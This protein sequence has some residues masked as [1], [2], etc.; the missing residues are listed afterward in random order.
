MIRPTLPAQ[1]MDR[2]FR[3]FKKIP[4]IFRTSI[5]VVGVIF[6]TVPA[7]SATDI[8]AATTTSVLHGNPTLAGKVAGVKLKEACK[9]RKPDLVLLYDYKSAVKTAEDRMAIVN[10]LAES[11]DRNSIYGAAIHG[12]MQDNTSR[13]DIGVIALGGIKMTPVKVAL[14]AGKEEASYT[15]LAEALKAPYAEAKD[16]GRLV[17]IYGECVPRTN[18]EK[19]MSA[20]TAALGKDVQLFGSPA[21]NVPFTYYQGELLNN[22]LVA[23]LITGDF[24]CNFAMADAAV[25]V[26]DQNQDPDR[27]VESAEKAMKSAVG[28]KKESAALIFVAYSVTRDHSMNKMFKERPTAKA[29]LDKVVRGGITAPLMT[30][31]DDLEIG[32]PA[33]GEPAVAKEDQFSVCVI[34]GKK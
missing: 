2:T 31:M 1:I 13:G 33:T 29:D 6:L 12:F 4:T 26:G 23:I 3:S 10:G 34:S 7:A 18:N 15:A 20:F 24:T 27:M 14:E 19:I 8:W 21:P 32:H 9:N 25:T 22:T 17:L 5:I 16:K 11:F 28:D 30:I